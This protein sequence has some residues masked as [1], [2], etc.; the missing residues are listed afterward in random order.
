MA[1]TIAS[2]RACRF[3]LF[4]CLSEPL[5]AGQGQCAI[6][7]CVRQARGPMRRKFE[8]NWPQHPRRTMCA[9]MPISPGRSYPTCSNIRPLGACPSLRYHQRRAGLCGTAKRRT[10]PAGLGP[11]CGARKRPRFTPR[12]T[13]GALHHPAPSPPLRGR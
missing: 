5:T 7:P 10:K 6:R 2:P 13:P 9:C 4:S 8:R 12:F 11:L 3:T 1:K